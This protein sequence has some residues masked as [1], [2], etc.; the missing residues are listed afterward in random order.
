MVALTLIRTDGGTQV[1]QQMD[2]A[3]V[4]EYAALMEG[5]L[6]FPPVALFAETGLTI[7]WLA[8]GFRRVAA[9]KKAG[10]TEI[11]AVVRGGTKRDAI[12]FAL[13]TNAKHGAQLTLA[14]RKAAAALLLREPEVRKWTSREL[15]RRCGIH[16][17]TAEKLRKQASAEVPH[18]R[19]ATRNGQ[20]YGINTWR[21]G[22][23]KKRSTKNKLPNLDERYEW[24]PVED[25][26]EPWVKD[27]PPG[28]FA[29][30][31]VAPAPAPPLSVDL[32][33]SIVGLAA[34]DA[35]LWYW[36][37][38]AY[39]PKVLKTVQKWGFDY[40]TVVTWVQPVAAKVPGA[41]IQD[42]TQHFV[43]AVRGQPKI[44]PARTTAILQRDVTDYT[45][46][47]E[48]HWLVKHTCEGAC[49]EVHARKPR[50]GWTTMA[51]SHE[52]QG[53]IKL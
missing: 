21:I 22:A 36:T 32:E 45:E 2:E 3:T 20:S 51:W 35:V 29:L 15:G 46:L 1:R 31:V 44:V 53:W 19:V 7:F 30:V 9:A 33:R 39:L 24:V 25:R 8:D 47:T 34:K 37:A 14:D 11:E 50:K 42:Q 6:R 48:L 52:T 26:V 5:G 17:K 23:R 28:P 27:I 41:W 40:Q 13:D 18:L 49:V 12:L 10:R 43:V 38:N 16:G 4:D